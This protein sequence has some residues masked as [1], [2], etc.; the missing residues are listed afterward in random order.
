MQSDYFEFI[1]FE[2]K[3]CSACEILVLIV[4]TILPMIWILL[5]VAWGSIDFSR[6]A[7]ATVSSTAL[8]AQERA[9]LPD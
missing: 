6:Q 1:C 9:F 7:P 4:F 2:N 8:V 3:Y 5:V